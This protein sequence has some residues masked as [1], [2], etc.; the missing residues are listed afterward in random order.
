MHAQ[1][2][3]PSVVADLGGPIWLIAQLPNLALLGLKLTA[4]LTVH[5]I[6]HLDRFKPILLRVNLLQRLPYLLAAL[7]LLLVPGMPW[8][9]LIAVV[10]APLMSGVF[11]GI[12]MTAWQQL[13]GI[14]V[15]PAGRISLFAFRQ[16]L[17]ASM[18]L[19][20]G[21]VVMLV[22]THQPGTTG[23]A[24]LHL[25]AFGLMMVSYGL[26]SIIHEPAHDRLP[27]ERSSLAAS[28]RSMLD[29]LRQ[30]SRL[31]SYVLTNSLFGVSGMLIPFLAMHA[32]Q[33]TGLTSSF[34]GSLLMWQMGGVMVGSGIAVWLGKAWGGVSVLL[35]AR[36]IF[37]GLAGLVLWASTPWQWCLIFGLLGAATNANFAGSNAMQLELLPYRKRAHFL[38]LI[39]A[40]QI[41][42]IITAG[43]VA[44]LTRATWGDAGTEILAIGSCLLVIASLM[45]LAS[46]LNR[47]SPTLEAS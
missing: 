31:R 7:A 45:P 36:I 4:L 2:L 15:P 38:A 19:A 37:L 20:A 34:L 44:Y 12:G 26:F 22:L 33:V 13:V 35:A 14:T 16:I 29:I 47:P 23:F 41:P 11:G 1:T 39:G 18:G 40:S 3:L 46:L 43:L 24:I 25:G 9:C 27:E 10:M 8:L 30:D 5:H 42:V 21:W 32:L 28:L 6:G 17:G